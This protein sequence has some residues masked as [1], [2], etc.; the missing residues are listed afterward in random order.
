MLMPPKNKIYAPII[1][2]IKKRLL[3][4]VS[5][6]PVFDTGKSLA[7]VRTGDKKRS[8]HF[9]LRSGDLT[10]RN[11]IKHDKMADARH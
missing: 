5:K 6:G 4:I 10:R 8:S 7:C 11:L 9:L 3:S 1:I 2:R